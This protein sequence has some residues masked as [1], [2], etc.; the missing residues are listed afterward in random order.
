[1]DTILT[2]IGTSFGTIFLLIILA[3][4]LYDKIEYIISR[5]MLGIASLF[6]GLRF[7]KKKGI[8]LNIQSRINISASNLQKKVQHE[9]EIEKIKIDWVEKNKTRK[10]FLEGDSVIIRLQKNDSNEQNFIHGT[11][12]FVSTCLLYKL[13]RHLD[14]NQ[15]ETMDLYVTAGLLNGSGN[16]VQD[17]YLEKYIIPS[18]EKS[19]K[20]K[21]YYSKYQTLDKHGY[22]YPLLITEL[23]YLGKK[24]FATVGQ[25]ELTSV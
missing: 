24:V 17:F 22:F 25:F 3:I 20:K 23:N 1:M 16:S 6:K 2:I 4:F 19:R 8:Q 21:S 12:L 15:K 14:K 5:I 13:K 7:L 9:L 11:H 10:A 18:I